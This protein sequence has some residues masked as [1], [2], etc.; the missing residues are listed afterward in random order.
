[1][2]IEN[3]TQALTAVRQQKPLVVNITNYVVMNNTANALLAIGASPIMAHSKQE[4]A[5]MMS[6]AGALVINIGTLDSEWIPRMIF[7][8]EQANANGKVVVLDPVGCGASTLRTETSRQI[9]RLA[10]K[11][12]IRGN[13][14]EIIALAGEQAQSK[15]VD[16]LDSSDAALGAAQFL[17]AE[18]GAN[19]VISGETDYIVTKSQTVT[20]GNGHEMMPYVTGMGCTLS[21]LTGAFAAVG[22]ETGLAAAAVLGVAGEI[23]AE[24]AR[25]PG[26]LQLT[27]LDELYQLDEQTLAKRLKL[28][29]IKD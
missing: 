19:V 13:A 1:M 10:D 23:A 2:L 22:D 9:A 25:G 24:Q 12:I 29:V 15:G 27:L 26:S 3:I 20:L 8:V 14:S 6:F 18:Y 7:A 28:T 5:E 21:A 4:M 11:L 16:S 17:V